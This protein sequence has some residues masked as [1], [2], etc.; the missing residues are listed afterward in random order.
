MPLV[1]ARNHGT[2]R[3]QGSPQALD[4]R[5]VSF[6]RDS[7][8]DDA[9][10]SRTML[11]GVTPAA[12]GHDQLALGAGVVIVLLLAYISR[13]Q[14]RNLTSRIARGTATLYHI[15][16]ST[17]ETNYSRLPLHEHEEERIES[18]TSSISSVQISRLDDPAPPYSPNTPFNPP[19]RTVSLNEDT[20]LSRSYVRL[21]AQT[22]S[23]PS[24][25][26]ARLNSTPS[27]PSN[28]GAPESHPSGWV[29]HRGS[30]PPPINTAPS[31]SQTVAQPAQHS[32]GYLL[33]TESPCATPPPQYSSTNNTPVSSSSG[34]G[35]PSINPSEFNQGVIPEYSITI[36]SSPRSFQ[37]M[38][39]VSG[40]PIAVHV[41]DIVL[42]PVP[43]LPRADTGSSD[44]NRKCKY[45][46]GDGAPPGYLE[47]PSRKRSSSRRRQEKK[48]KPLPVIPPAEIKLRSEDENIH[49]RNA[50]PRPQFTSSSSQEGSSTRNMTEQGTTP[51]TRCSSLPTRR[52]PVMVDE[53]PP[54]L[55]RTRSAPS[56]PPPMPVLPLDLEAV[57][58][59]GGSR[60]AEPEPSP[61]EFA[62]GDKKHPVASSEED[63]DMPLAQSL[64]LAMRKKTEEL[65]RVEEVKTKQVSNV[66]KMQIFGRLSALASRARKAI[67]HELESD[68]DDDGEQEE[69]EE[70]NRWEVAALREKE[71]HERTMHSRFVT[72][73]REVSEAFVIG[74]EDE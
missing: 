31:C 10:A 66:I 13:R 38:Y 68:D 74:D 37:Y 24:V 14:L 60:Q 1:H 19:T 73:E 36:H 61:V 17:R 64:L 23:A 6:P 4:K 15:T 40:R 50:K 54:P 55:Q 44:R 20:S 28:V 49:R 5:H 7:P 71:A 42:S 12:V 63:E 45:Y 41:P 3:R 22:P 47:V 56:M 30:R 29:S 11:P 32:S 9:L 51:M 2:K 52:K 57:Y 69:K 26:A 43:W 18:P 46:I 34:S 21:Q 53:A 27:M 72:R 48:E 39:D 35:T 59:S 33:Q 62:Y 58:P 16:T 67:E 8:S 70:E 65:K 25:L